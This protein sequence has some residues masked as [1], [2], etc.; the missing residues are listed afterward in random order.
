MARGGVGGGALWRDVERG[1]IGEIRLGTMGRLKLTLN[2]GGDG[3]TSFENI[4]GGKKRA[5][6]ILGE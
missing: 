6:L 5:K 1:S 2:D 3:L 4:E